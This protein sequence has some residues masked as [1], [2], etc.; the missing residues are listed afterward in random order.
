MVTELKIS[1]QEIAAAVA[2]ITALNTGIYWVFMK[3]DEEHFDRRYVKKIYAE[4]EVRRLDGKIDLSEQRLNVKIDEQ[5]KDFKEES[6]EIKGL[7]NGLSAKFDRFIELFL[8]KDR[9]NV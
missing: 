4:A 5:K 9:P 1:I 6:V 8:S 2:I 3:K 7:I